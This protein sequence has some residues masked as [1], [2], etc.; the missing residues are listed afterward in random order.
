LLL[1]M[2]RS[3]PSTWSRCAD[4]DLARRRLDGADRDLP[5][6]RWRAARSRERAS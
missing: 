6:G 4:I 2:R 3:C 5:A 1:M